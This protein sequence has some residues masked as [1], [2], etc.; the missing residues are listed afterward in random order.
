MESSR[1]TKLSGFLPLGV[2]LVL[3]A[4]LQVAWGESRE[5]SVYCELKHPSHSHT[6]KL[7]TGT[8]PGN[9]HIYYVKNYCVW[10]NDEWRP[11]SAKC[12]TPPLKLT[13]KCND[14]YQ[15]GGVN[16]VQMR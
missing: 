16:D 2:C 7:G 12:R 6:C 5:T 15:D 8:M 1:L 10:G 9:Y 3:L 14:A 11:N 13:V 4:A